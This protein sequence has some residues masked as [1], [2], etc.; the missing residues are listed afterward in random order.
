MRICSFFIKK[1]VHLIGRELRLQADH[2]IQWVPVFQAVGI[3]L[4]FS[5]EYEPTAFWVITLLISGIVLVFMIDQ[6]DKLIPL[7]IIA[8]GIVGFVCAYARTSVLDLKNFVITDKTYVKDKVGTLREINYRPK[9]VQLLICD[10]EV[11]RRKKTCIRLAVRTVINPIIQVGDIIKFT[12]VISPPKA[13]ISHNGYD[14]ARDAYFKGIGATGFTT[15]AVLLQEKRESIRFL[16]WIERSRIKTYERF[17]SRL[18]RDSTEVLSALL[19]GKRQGIREEILRD[20][21]NSGLAHLLAISGLHLSCVAGM[22]FVFL[23]YIFACSEKLTLIYNTKKLC[24]GVAIGVSFYYLLLAGMPI[25]ACRAF[26]MVSLTFCGIIMDRRHNSMRS[27]SV[28]A[29]I[30]L[31]ATPEAILSPSFQMSFAAVISLVSFGNISCSMI[32]A[33]NIL[34]YLLATATVSLIA[35][36]A[37]APYVIYHFH[38]FSI[39]GVLANVVAVP[40]ATFVVI[41]L[42]VLYLVTCDTFF[43]PIIA[44]LLEWAVSFLLYIAHCT[45]LTELFTSFCSIPSSS[46]LLVT[47][48]LLI[49]ALC[50]GYLRIFG[51]VIFTV[52][53]ALSAIT[54]KTPDIICDDTAVVV[55][56]RDANLHF[57]MRNGDIRGFKYT[58]WARDNGQGRIVKQGEFFQDK[59]LVCEE[60]GCTYKDRVLITSDSSFLIAH[61]KNMDLV[62]CN[63]QTTY[64]E[65]CSDIKHI[66]LQDIRDYGIHYIWI[67]EASV[68][69]EKSI[70]RRPWH[71][72]AKSSTYGA[73]IR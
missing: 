47:L 62:I 31:L 36:L 20:V 54:Y 16:D 67:N 40:T 44:F 71:K 9:H 30:I 50:T 49:A 70:K 6:S 15:S 55:K 63:A 59:I 48:G 41:P 21:R 52:L 33:N 28:A 64:P 11:S 38:E 18:S 24:S 45:A 13:P 8:L 25:S 5:L 58:Q 68:Y 37:T 3:I 73:V 17:A 4:Y 69:V 2:L 22:V 39:A 53:G 35:S 32:V 43:S 51:G 29:S 19:I 72:N 23:R 1:F 65:E 14:F 12:G 27:L 34:R 42:G 46:V 66:G 26:I 7:S 10:V 57:V 61:C 60:G 56:G